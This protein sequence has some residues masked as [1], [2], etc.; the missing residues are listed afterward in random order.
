M[1]T[2]SDNQA[3][4]AALACL[5]SSCIFLLVR[6]ETYRG[7]KARAKKMQDSPAGKTGRRSVIES[8]WHDCT[9]ANVISMKAHSDSSGRGIEETMFQLKYIYI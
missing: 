1:T 4:A 9:V 8:I 3:E 7:P 6:S 2:C 5:E